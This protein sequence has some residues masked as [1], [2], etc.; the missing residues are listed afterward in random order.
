MYLVEEVE[1][2]ELASVQVFVFVQ[3]SGINEAL[4]NL[5]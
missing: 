4:I 5:V 2:E 1:L 3:V